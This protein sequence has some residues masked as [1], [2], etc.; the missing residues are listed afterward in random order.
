MNSASHKF[1]DHCLSIKSLEVEYGS[2]WEFAEDK[3]VSSNF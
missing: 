1:P 3:D 2:T